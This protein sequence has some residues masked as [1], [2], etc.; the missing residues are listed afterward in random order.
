[1]ALSEDTLMIDWFIW[2]FEPNKCDAFTQ[3][4]HRFLFF[5]GMHDKR[6]VLLDIRQFKS[7]SLDQVDCLTK[8][9]NENQA[10]LKANFRL[11]LIAYFTT[12]RQNMLNIK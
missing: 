6:I 11:E 5:E 4:L 7:P 8:E 10:M 12:Y 1:M 3:L 2:P 9:C